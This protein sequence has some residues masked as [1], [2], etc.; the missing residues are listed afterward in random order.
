MSEAPKT[1]KKFTAAEVAVHDGGLKAKALK[2]QLEKETDPAAKKA[3]EAQILAAPLDTWIIIHGLVF[4]VT[5]FKNKH[6]GGPQSFVETAGQDAT[7]EFEELYHSATA[8]EMLRDM[9]VGQLDTYDG[10][11]ERV[12]KFTS[13]DQASQN[14]GVVIAVG[15]AVA[16]AL[17]YAFF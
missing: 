9:T 3:L 16:A 12:Y 17:Y 14:L 1:Y 2:A 4:D 13:S 7:T 11:L 10:D 6:P 5:K 8:R 15:V